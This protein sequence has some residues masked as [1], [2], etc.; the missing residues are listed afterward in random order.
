MYGSHPLKFWSK[1]QIAVALSSAEA[2]LNG[3]VKGSIEGLG[4]ITM[5]ADMGRIV[6]G[7]VYTD[8]SA[9]KAVVM[10]RG[11]GKV[12]HLRTQQLWVQEVHADGRL[13]FLKIPR[14]ANVADNL[15]HDWDASSGPRLLKLMGMSVRR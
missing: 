2:E 15:T 11:S 12:K 14:C 9:A 5:F 7:C 6:S 8:S 13:E 10:R 3:M 1:T 4:V